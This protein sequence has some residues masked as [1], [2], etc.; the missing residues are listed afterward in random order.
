M[1]IFITGYFFL[2]LQNRLARTTQR[3]VMHFITEQWSCLSS[4]YSKCL[5]FKL[6][7]ATL[8]WTIS[9]NK[10]AP[11][12]KCLKLLWWTITPKILFWEKSVKSH[13][14]TTLHVSVGETAQNDLF[15]KSPR[16]CNHL[17]GLRQCKDPQNFSRKEVTHC[18]RMCCCSMFQGSKSSFLSVTYKQE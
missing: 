7:S 17:L 10:T 16:I 15:L 6:V 18:F 1:T 8:Q 4:L 5:Q 2:F 13:N 14:R 3:Y 12:T 9:R 11:N